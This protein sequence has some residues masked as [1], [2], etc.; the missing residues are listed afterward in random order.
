MLLYLKILTYTQYT[1]K[2][3]IA[4]L[5]PYVLPSTICDQLLLVVKMFR[6]L[7]T[8][9]TCRHTGLVRCYT[10]AGVAVDV[11]TLC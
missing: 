3:Y 5:V 4:H 6:S 1:H 11:K 8:Q 2:I 7:L 10:T 9:I